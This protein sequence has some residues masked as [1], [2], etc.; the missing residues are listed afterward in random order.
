M[1]L[2]APSGTTSSEPV[3]T[4]LSPARLLDGFVP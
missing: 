1:L 4:A 2:G 3:N